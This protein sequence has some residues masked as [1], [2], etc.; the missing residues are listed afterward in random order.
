MRLHA[1]ALCFLFFG[2][3]PLIIMQ[4]YFCF[5]I[6]VFTGFFPDLFCTS[7]STLKCSLQP[8]SS[9]I[10]SVFFPFSQA[11]AFF[12]FSSIYT[13][14]IF[15]PPPEFGY[16]IGFL[17]FQLEY[18]FWV[19][20]FSWFSSEVGLPSSSALIAVRLAPHYFTF[21]KTKGPLSSTVRSVS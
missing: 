21:P 14:F 2:S 12:F 19:F 5:L 16:V 3:P 13:V 4:F 18:L 9:L 7:D 15:L 1:F 11:C 6:Y 17:S 10:F 8:C 20:F